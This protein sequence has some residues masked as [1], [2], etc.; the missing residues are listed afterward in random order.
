MLE[1]MALKSLWLSPFLRYT[2]RYEQFIPL[3]HLIV[4]DMKKTEQLEQL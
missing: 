2:Y 1:E 4:G 3:S